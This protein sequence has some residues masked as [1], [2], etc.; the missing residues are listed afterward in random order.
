MAARSI[1]CSSVAMP[2]SVA[3]LLS[4]SATGG[5]GSTKKASSLQA[6]MSVFGA[7]VWLLPWTQ[8]RGEQGRVCRGTTGV[9]TG[10]RGV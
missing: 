4:R 1:M 10:A 3:M 8:E 6:T 9:A 7:Q 2:S 5:G